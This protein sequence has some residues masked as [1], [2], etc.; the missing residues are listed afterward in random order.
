M[1]ID[2]L[3]TAANLSVIPAWLLLILAPQ[4]KLTHTLVHS[5]IYPAVL[6]TAYI[7]GMLTSA[8]TAGAVDMGSLAGL[9]AAFA[10]PA[11]MLVG[12]IHYLVFDLFVG[13]WEA[14]DAARR[15]V[16]RLLLIPCLIL[17]FMLGPTGLLLY[18]IIRW[19]RS[20]STTLMEAA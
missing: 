12:W 6:G 17:T 13:A 2:T 11:M 5:M 9:S 20:R 1:T 14:R 16:P 7:V 8:S 4:A 3:F 10:N 18:L 15:N 19:F